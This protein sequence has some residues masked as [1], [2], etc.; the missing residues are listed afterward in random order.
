MDSKELFAI[1]EKVT[2]GM[3]T[4]FFNIGK[5]FYSREEQ[6]VRRTAE[7]EINRVNKRCHDYEELKALYEDACGQLQHHKE[8]LS[9]M[10]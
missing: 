3:Q 2:S 8:Q 10:Q 7:I 1:Q 4:G 6:E 5:L 9:E